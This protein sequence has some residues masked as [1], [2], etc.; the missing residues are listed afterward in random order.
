MKP[1]AVGIALIV[2]RAEN[3]IIGSGGKL[4]WHISAD[5]QYFKRLTVGKPIIMGRKTYDS[6]GR[7]LPRRTNIVVTGSPGWHADGVQVAADLPTAF[8]LAFEDAHRT[9][10]EEVMVIGGGTLYSQ[11]LP[12]VRRIY[13]TEVH[14]AYDGDAVFDFVPTPPWRETA[15]EDHAAEGDQPAFSFVT[16]ERE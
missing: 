2:A 10:A 12:Q 3:G 4:P 6:I 8:A 7:P 16:W 9:G 11:S 14:R 13:L 1:T 15:R 5:L